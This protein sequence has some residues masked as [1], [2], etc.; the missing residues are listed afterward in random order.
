MEMKKLRI[1]TIFTV[2][3]SITNLKAQQNENFTINHQKEIVG[4]LSEYNVPAVGIGILK[5]GKL[6]ECKVYGKQRKNILVS[7]S[8]IF[9]IASLTK[10]IVAMVTLKLV[11]N[12][13]WN[14]DEPLANYW[15]DPDIENDALL[16]KLTIRTVLTH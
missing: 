3:I 16:K 15:I 4:W 2:I 14:L 6:S 7:D 5:N 13:Q 11:E 9:T 10:P 1:L 12:E 8:T